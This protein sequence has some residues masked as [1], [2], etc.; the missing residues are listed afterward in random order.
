[1]GD[2]I[3]AYDSMEEADL[4]LDNYHKKEKPEDLECD[5]AWGHIYS[6]EDEK[7]V[8]EYGVGDL[9]YLELLPCNNRAEK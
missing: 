6:L 9:L 1:M 2:F 4:A 8:A 3:G 7:L 5:E